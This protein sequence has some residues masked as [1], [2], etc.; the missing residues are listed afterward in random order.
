[1]NG[2][3]R[4]AL[5]AKRDQA[6]SAFA[7]ILT[8]LVERIPGARAAAL[9]DFDGETVDYASCDDPFEV[10]LA[11]AH[12]RIVLR[13][14]QQAYGDSC[15][16]SVRAANRSFLVRAL[17]QGYALTLVLTCGAATAS[18]GRAVPV[19]VKRLAAEAGWDGPMALL[20][21]PVDV[22]TDERGRPVAMTTAKTAATVEILGSVAGGLARFERGWR[23]RL[24]GGEATIVRE[25]S[26]HWYVDE[27]LLAGQ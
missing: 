2:S 5:H 21:H 19:C 20:W 22:R 3:A 24:G 25:P 10:R 17:P 11:A 1:L 13:E 26:G 16:L 23:V 27:P 14:L 7:A 9:V 18:L 15:A 8:D 4:K 6:E 12:L